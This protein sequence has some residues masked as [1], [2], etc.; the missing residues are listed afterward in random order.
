MQSKLIKTIV[1][2]LILMLCLPVFAGARTIHH[3]KHSQI[4]HNKKTKKVSTKKKTPAKK[5]KNKKPS[6]PKLVVSFCHKM[7]VTAFLPQHSDGRRR[8][9]G[10]GKYACKGSVAVSYRQIP[11]GS[12]MYIQGYGWGR[13]V[14]TGGAMKKDRI[15]ICVPNMK[16]ARKW[17]R[18]TVWVTVYKTKK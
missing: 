8:H 16:A 11:K 18:R 7:V 1:I 17:G 15:D 10:N 6:S 12:K 2:I 14:S 3:K 4:S 13:A 5:K 9:I